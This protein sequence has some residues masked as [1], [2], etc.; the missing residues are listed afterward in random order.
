MTHEYPDLRMSFNYLTGQNRDNKR[1]LRGSKL[2]S[3]LANSAS[4]NRGLPLEIEALYVT[5]RF[6][7][8]FPRILY[9]REQKS[10]CLAAPRKLMVSV[11]SA[12]LKKMEVLPFF[13]QLHQAFSFEI[14]VWD[15]K[16]LKH[17]N[18]GKLGPF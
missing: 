4:N 3:P 17:S 16:L 13:S 15:S 10:A 7:P 12:N 18:W 5:A 11:L 6:L 9:D 2:P 14:V 8:S 1:A